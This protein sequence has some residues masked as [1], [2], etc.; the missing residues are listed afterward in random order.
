M[1]TVGPQILKVVACIL[2]LL[3]VI[4][5]LS[6]PKSEINWQITSMYWNMVSVTLWLYI[7]FTELNERRNKKN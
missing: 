5:L 7:I 3:A 1:K 2:S 6:R 4:Y